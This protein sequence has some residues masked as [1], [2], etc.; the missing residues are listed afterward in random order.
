M[1]SIQIALVLPTAMV[2]C[3]VTL[4]LNCDW[5]ALQQPAGMTNETSAPPFGHSTLLHTVIQELHLPLLIKVCVWGGGLT[6]RNNARSSGLLVRQ[7]FLHAN[8]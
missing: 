8:Q 2:G 5:P 3:H 1:S 6:Q 4:G 7:I